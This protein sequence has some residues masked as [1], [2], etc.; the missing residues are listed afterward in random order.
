MLDLYCCAGG[1]ARG[2][3]LA[4][5]EVDGVDV[6]RQPR[7]AGDRF[8]QGDA[9]EYLLEHGHEYDAV[10][11]SPP[12]QADCTLTL[13]TNQHLAGNHTSWIA[14]TRAA[15]LIVG[16][17]YVIEQPFPSR[18]K[19]RK[20]VMLCGLHFGLKVFRHRQFE[21]GGWSMPNLAHKQS[22]LHAGHRVA[23][24]RHGVRY[25]GDMVAP[26]GDGG[27]KGSAADWQAAMGID[28]TDDKEELAEAIPPAYT[29]HIGAALALHVDGLP[30]AA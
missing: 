8:V 19:M 20:D 5:W 17:P 28:W 4:G 7:Y 9:I 3:Q 24:W 6:V 27:G 29:R 25:E 2:Y 22:E 14:A 21:L 26:Y 10:H 1:A 23:G 15:L 11:A 16:R 12:C 18:A 13:G 30:E